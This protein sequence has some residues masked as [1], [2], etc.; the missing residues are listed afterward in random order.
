MP[1]IKDHFQLHFIVLI[2]GFT[3]IIGLMVSIPS[4]ELVFYRTGLASFLLIFLVY[5]YG[6]SFR[7][8]L[9]SLLAI[10]GTGAIIAAHWILFFASA[11]ISTASVCLAGMT[12]TSLWTSILEPLFYRRAIRGY[13]VLLALII[14]G[15][16]YVIFRFEVNHLLG[17]V[18]AIC[19]ALLAALF[20][21]INSQ[22][23]RYHNHYVITF[24]EMLGAS[25]SIA[26][27]FPIY[28]LYFSETP[29]LQLTPT[30]WDIL[31]IFILAGVCTV[32]AYSKGVQLMHKFTPFALNLTVN[33]EPVYGILLAFLIFGE[34]EKMTF[35]FYLGT[36]I[37]LGAVLSYPL[38]KKSSEKIG[39]YRQKSKE[40]KLSTAA[41]RE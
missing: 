5:G 6:Q 9:P 34:K 22:L 37:I 8:S 15:G 26:L 19:S 21:I 4:V 40:R 41:S 35:G 18:F 25:L 13:E 36:L 20:S 1:S 23:V 33:L 30:N 32:Y 2:W 11:K 10:M 31:L 7:V 12:T 27:F 38:F 14:I 3:A 39:Q 17:L 16:L 28:L 29:Y 24:Y